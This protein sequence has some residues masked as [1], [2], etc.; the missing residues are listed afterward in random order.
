MLPE[1]DVA[2]YDTVSVERPKTELTEEEFEGEL[3]GMLDRQA[4]VETVEEERAL[5]DG[6]WA[7]IQFRGEIKPLAETVTEEG[8]TATIRPRRRSRARTC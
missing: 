6:D 7:E 5:A 1:F 2:G 3:D 8:V 4:T